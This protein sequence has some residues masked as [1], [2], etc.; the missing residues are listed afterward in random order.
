[1]VMN[2]VR[3]ALPFTG[4]RFFFITSSTLHHLTMF[5]STGDRGLSTFSTLFVCLFV[6]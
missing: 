5:L 2:S 3:R 4:W 6:C 1:M